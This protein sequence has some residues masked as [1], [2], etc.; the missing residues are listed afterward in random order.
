MGSQP[1]PPLWLSKFETHI[2]DDATLFERYMNDIPRSIKRELIEQNLRD[3]NAILTNL[4][5]TLEV[6]Q[7]HK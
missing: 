7:E 6:E 4:S 3:I 2:R 1:A 5:L